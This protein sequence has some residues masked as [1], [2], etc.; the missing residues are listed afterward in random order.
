MKTNESSS[1][2]NAFSILLYSPGNLWSNI[3]DVSFE[4][5]SSYKI[6][7]LLESNIIFLSL[8]NTV[9]AIFCN[10]LKILMTHS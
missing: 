10:V 7:L 4:K 9:N 1:R 3:F 6:I 8:D 2:V 5:V